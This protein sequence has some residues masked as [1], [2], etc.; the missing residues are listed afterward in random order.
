MAVFY[1]KID[2]F[3][4]S[5]TTRAVYSSLEPLPASLLGTSAGVSVNDIF[6]VIQSL[7]RRRRLAEGRRVPVPSSRSTSCPT[8]SGASASSATSPM[9]ISNVNYGTKA[10]PKYNK[11]TGQSKTTANATIYFERGK[12]SA[13]TPLA[14]RSGFL[15]QFPASN[16]NGEHG[17]H[18]STYYDFRR[19]ATKLRPNLVVTLEGINL[20]DKFADAYVDTAD[21]PAASTATLAVRSCWACAGR[22]LTASRS[23]LPWAWRPVLPAPGP[24]FLESNHV[25]ARRTVL[26]LAAAAPATPTP[27]TPRPWPQQATTPAATPPK[28]WI[29]PGM[30]RPPHRAAVG[31]GRQQEPL[32]PPAR[33][34]AP[35][36]QAG[37]HN[38]VGHLRSGRLLED[39]QADGGPQDQGRRPAVLS[40]A[41]RGCALLTRSLRAGR[42]PGGRPAPGLIYALDIDSGRAKVVGE[43]AQ[44][45]DHYRSTPTRPCC[46]GSSPTAASRCS[47]RPPTTS[48]ASVKAEYAA[49]GPDGKPLSFAKAKGR[50]DDRALRDADPDGDLHARPEDR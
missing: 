41:A 42:G 19:R 13:R 24:L 17:T 3:I 47:P 6:D 2:S 40:C 29:D 20:G 38:A 5:Q 1:K 16:G 39:L 30:T 21:R 44:G 45:P 26:G 23:L 35:G 15:T 14:R 27:A 36:R 11:L 28:D 10:A 32:F 25:I 46:W 43:L 37:D 9:S 50:A 12:F 8:P 49:L 34:H 33:L 48:S 31:R 7:Q 18:G 22:L 4:A